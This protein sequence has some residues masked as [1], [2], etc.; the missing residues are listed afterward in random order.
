MGP[1]GGCRW[2][3][4]TVPLASLD[5]P[6]GHRSVHHAKDKA[7]R[8][9]V[10]CDGLP[11]GQLQTAA[12]PWQ[13]ALPR[14]PDQGRD[15]IPRR[16]RLGDSSPDLRI[17]SRKRVVHQ[18]LAPRGRARGCVQASMIA[19]SVGCSLGCSHSQLGMPVN[20]LVRTCFRGSF[21]GLSEGVGPVGDPEKLIKMAT[22]QRR[23]RL[24]LEAAAAAARCSIALL[25]RRPSVNPLQVC[26]RPVVNVQTT[27]R[28]GDNTHDNRSRTL[29]NGHE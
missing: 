10:P 9:P 21:G 25:L 2:R 19:Q 7:H 3:L 29:P 18:V 27:P 26:L 5:Q 20:P 4:A 16:S 14:D 11:G 1:R 8:R 24:R 17:T 22:G 13:Q 28:G 12:A 6:P 23:R 15:P